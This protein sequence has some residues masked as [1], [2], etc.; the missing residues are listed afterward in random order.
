MA[1]EYSQARSDRKLERGATQFIEKAAEKARYWRDQKG[2]KPE[3]MPEDFGRDMVVRD[4]ATVTAR[5]AEIAR[6]DTPEQKEEAKISEVFEVSL[7]WL[8]QNRGFL[9]K[10][11]KQYCRPVTTIT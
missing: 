6:R 3:K 7:W 2:I 5:A 11:Q 10:R 1:Y 8:A 4:T 9:G